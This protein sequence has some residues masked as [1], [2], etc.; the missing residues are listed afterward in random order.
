MG[1]YLVGTYHRRRGKEI[2]RQTDGSGSRK[3]KIKFV[4]K[5]SIKTSSFYFFLNFEDIIFYLPDNIEGIGYA[6]LHIMTLDF[7]ALIPEI[8]L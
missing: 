8:S 7:A 6:Y 1:V 5:S 2:D 4:H 3:E